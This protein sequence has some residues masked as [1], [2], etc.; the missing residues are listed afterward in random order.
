MRAR[1]SAYALHDLGFVQKTMIG[2]AKEQ[3]HL[4]DVNKAASQMQ[5]LRLDVVKREQKGSN[6]AFVEFI[7]FYSHLGKKGSLHERSEFHKIDDT[8]YYFD[9]TLL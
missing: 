9:G 3:F 5:W 2:P 4:E 6:L 1:Y 8:W 7:A